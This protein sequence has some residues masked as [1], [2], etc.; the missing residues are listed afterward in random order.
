V[1]ERTIS[2]AGDPFYAAAKSRPCTCYEGTVYI[3]RVVES[4]HDLGG[5]VV[6]YRAVP[7][8]RCGEAS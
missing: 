6:E 8:R 4:K 2:V 1:D 5:E 7:C 3:G